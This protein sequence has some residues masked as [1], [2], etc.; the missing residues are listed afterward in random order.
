MTPRTEEKVFDTRCI[1]AEGVP[2]VW[3]EIEPFVLMGLNA[4]KGEL[5]L[6]DVRVLLERGFQHAMV[7]YHKDR[8]EMLFIVEVHN[9]PQYKVLHISLIAGRNLRD[10]VKFRP[11]LDAMATAM[12][13][14]EIRAYCNDAQM[15]LYRMLKLGFIKIYN[16]IQSDL[17]GKY[18]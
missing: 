17:R 4:A 2:E 12:G 1:L 14:M 8:L 3:D 6:Q 9:Y 7:A 18:Q 13:C 16:V 15:R 10:V 5:S 11:A